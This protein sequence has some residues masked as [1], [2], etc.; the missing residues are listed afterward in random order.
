M[1][2]PYMQCILCERFLGDTEN[3]TCEAFPNGI[4]SDVY[5]GRVLHDVPLENDNGLQFIRKED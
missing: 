4:E 3:P 2:T 5:W 1:T